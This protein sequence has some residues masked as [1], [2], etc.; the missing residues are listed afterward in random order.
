MRQQALLALKKGPTDYR[1]AL[2]STALRSGKISFE[3]VIQ[4]ID[5]MVALLGE[6]QKTD[7]EKKAYCEAEL[8]KAEDELKE[9]ELKAEDLT[10][11]IDDDKESIAKLTEEITAL[12]DGIKALDKAVAEATVQRKEIAAL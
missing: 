4:M 3:K 1:V 7:D 5:D 2:I 12:E 10:K 11:A 9:L 6:E 8:D